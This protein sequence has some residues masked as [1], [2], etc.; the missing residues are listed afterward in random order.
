MAVTTD[1]LTGVFD[2]DGTHSSFQFA[3]RHMKVSTFRAS[4][5][6]VD[7]RLIADRPELRLEGA[8]RVESI[9]ITDPT[10]FRAHVVRGADFFDA[11]NHPRSSFAP[12]GSSWPRTLTATVEGEL[13]IKAISRPITATGTWERPVEDTFGSLRAALGSEPSST[14]ATGG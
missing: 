7:V 14:G 10:E 13:T 8:A 1:P 4:F 9:S 5:G 3:V 2:A 6:D 12:T 11:D